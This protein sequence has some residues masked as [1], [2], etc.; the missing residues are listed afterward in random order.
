MVRVAIAPLLLAA[1]AVPAALAM[2]PAEAAAAPRVARDLAVIAGADG[3]TG[4]GGLEDLSHLTDAELTAAKARV[5][6][7]WRS[8]GKLRRD[9][10]RLAELEKRA[11]VRFDSIVAEL[12]RRRGEREEEA[13]ARRR[14]GEEALAEAAAAEQRR[15]SVERQVRERHSALETRLEG[16]RAEEERRVAAEAEAQDARRL[17]TAWLVG[18]G[19]LA[20]SAGLVAL[21]VVLARR[22]GTP[23]A[24]PAREALPYR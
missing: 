16:L 21:S 3:D 12:D 14:A 18:G 15:A 17:A 2:L 13:R 24:A 5:E 20:F 22:R 6:A 23:G 8:R 11:R 10:R 9:P 1:A 4:E 7:W 19:T